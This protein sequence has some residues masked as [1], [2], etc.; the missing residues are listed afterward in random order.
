MPPRKPP[1]ERFWAKV[2]RRD[3]VEC[4]DWTGARNHG[5]YGIFGL[6]FSPRSGTGASLEQARANAAQPVG[7]HVRAHRYAYEDAV[8]PV[9]ADHEV[10]HTCENRACVN[11]AHLEPLTRDEHVRLH[12]RLGNKWATRDPGNTRKRG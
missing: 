10:H 1:S 5:G 4:W 2:D 9:P 7:S 6:G 8:G 12:E 11:P 3:A